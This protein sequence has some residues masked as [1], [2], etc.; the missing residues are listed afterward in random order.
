MANWK[1]KCGLHRCKVLS[2][3]LSVSLRHFLL[4]PL[5]MDEAKPLHTILREGPTS[6]L[7]CKS[8]SAHTQ[9]RADMRRTLPGILYSGKS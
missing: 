6:G 1:G 5:S 8:W 4:L 7:G 9:H 2:F 3:L